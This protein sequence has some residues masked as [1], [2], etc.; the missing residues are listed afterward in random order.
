MKYL[1][2]KIEKNE[3]SK[4][5]IICLLHVLIYEIQN[6]WSSTATRAQNLKIIFKV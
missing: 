2:K 1:K 3:S 5:C 6:I 4:F